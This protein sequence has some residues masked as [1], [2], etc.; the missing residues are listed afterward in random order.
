MKQLSHWDM[1]TWTMIVI[2]WWWDGHTRFSCHVLICFD[3]GAYGNSVG[4]SHGKKWKPRKTKEIHRCSLLKV[5]SVFGCLKKS[6]IHA[7][8]MSVCE[9]ENII[10][11]FFNHEML[12]VIFFPLNMF[13]QSHIAVECCRDMGSQW[14]TSCWPLAV[15]IPKRATQIHKDNMWSAHEPYTFSVCIC[16]IVLF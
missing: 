3:H 1:I 10:I 8:P 7:Q 11:G 2:P 16:S 14:V 6:V 13:R 4:S 5:I 9:R 15:S 12:R